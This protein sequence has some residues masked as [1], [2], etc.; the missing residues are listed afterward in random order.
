MSDEW[1]DGYDEYEADWEDDYDSEEDDYEGDETGPCPECGA[2]LHVD[3]ESC[4]ACGHWLT[5][6]E[7]HRLWDGGSPVRD[8]MGIGKFVLIVI[9]IA[10]MSG[11][12]LS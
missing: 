1:D 4:Y 8:A 2:Q 3:A 11:F 9:L 5:T 12:L 10:L 7:R 6:A